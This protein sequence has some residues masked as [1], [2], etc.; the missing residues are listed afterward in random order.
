[1]ELIGIHQNRE[2]GI[3]IDRDENGFYLVEIDG[4]R[5]TL[6]CLE[7]MPNLFSILEG[8]F[9]YEVR[10]H[11]SKPGHMETHFYQNS[12][13]LEI[14]DPMKKIL[15]DSMGSGK[16]AAEL[17]APMPG[18]VQ[19]VLVAEGDQVEMDQPL[20]VL[21][22]M[23]MENALSSPKA[24]VVQKVLVKEGDDVEGNALLVIIA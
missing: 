23:K 8:D 22:A 24:G 16:G 4:R 18:K 7:L 9:S 20:V 15:E 2:Y 11:Q 19:Q 1:M 6:D 17:S 14:S 12:Y 5:Y 13:E 10:V 21:V 3:Q